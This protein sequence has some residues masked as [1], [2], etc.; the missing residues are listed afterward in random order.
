MKVCFVVCI[1]E[2]W[3]LS[4]MQQT[5]HQEVL[6]FPA[7][8]TIVSSTRRGISPK[9]AFYVQSTPALTWQILNFKFFS[10]IYCQHIHESTTILRL[11]IRINRLLLVAVPSGQDSADVN[12]SEQLLSMN[13]HL[14]IT[15]VVK[16]SWLTTIHQYSYIDTAGKLTGSVRVHEPTQR[17][18][19]SLDQRRV[20]RHFQNKV[21]QTDFFYDVQKH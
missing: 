2:Y 14:Q 8:S 5:T 18:T 10:L 17:G 19:R 3:L 12:F 21:R 16:I 4:V 7:S 20:R 9:H 1:G 13:F 15:N 11:M 6:I